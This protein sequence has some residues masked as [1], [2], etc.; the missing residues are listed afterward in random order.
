[1]AT[2]KE[3][4]LMLTSYP[5]PSPDGHG[6]R[7]KEI[8]LNLFALLLSAVLLLRPG[9]L[10]QTAQSTGGAVSIKVGQP[11]FGFNVLPNATRRIFAT[12]SNGTT[13]QVHWSIKSGSA[14]ISSSSGSWIDVTAPV[15][16]TSC[17]YIQTAGQYSVNSATQFTIEATSV[18]DGTKSADVIF[19]VCNPPV[20][21]SVVPFYRTLYANQAADVQSLVVGSVNTNVQWTLS[22]QP[23]GGDGKLIDTTTRDTVFSATVA[24]RYVLTAASIADPRQSSTAIMYVTGNTMPYRVTPNLT[25]P[26]DCTVDPTL[27]GK[28]YE[29]GPSQAF[30]RLQDVPFPRMAPGSTVRVHNEDTTGLHPTEYHEYV[31]ISQPAAADQPFRMCGV[32]DRAG[33]LPVLDAA[34]ATGRSDTSMYAA[35]YGLITLHQPNYWAYWPNFV[36]AAFVQVEGLHIRNATTGSTYTAPNGSTASWGDFSAGIRVNQGEN[37]TFVGNDIGG[38]GNGVFTAWNSGGGWGSADLNVLWEGNHIHNNGVVGSYLSHQMYLQAWGQVVQFN[39]VDSYTA[40]AQGSNIK[41]RGMLDI[42]RYNYLGDGAARQMDL[43][44][45]QDGPAYMSFEG[46]LSGGTHSYKAAYANDSYP[47]DQLAAQQEAYNSNFVYGN[48]YTNSS[49]NVPIH[50]AEDQIGN[51]LARKGSLYWYNNTFYEKLCASCSGQKWTLFDTTAGSGGTIIPQ[52]EYQ[53]VQAFD[54]VIAMDDPARPYFFWNNDSAFI[55]VSGKNLLTTNWGTNDMTGGVGTGWDASEV[56]YQSAQQLSLH[57]TGFNST[58]LQTTSAIP[59][60]KLSLILTSS[61]SGTA[62]LPSA[63]CQ[64]PTRFAYLPSISYAVPRTASLNMGATDTAAQTAAMMNSV[65]GNRRTN[66]RY[67]NCH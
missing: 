39:R 48:I 38:N 60:D 41:S 67:S 14:Q 28:T 27:L 32:P 21:V 45:V 5:E 44:D 18:D 61:A 40:G 51:E 29:V 10:M 17:Q 9:F 35:G 52:V 19:N 66:T 4:C 37:L 22:A 1:M 56:T 46:F 23:A 54:N 63:I 26:V 49:S 36:A 16:G 34:N 12:V 62:T 31:Q 8:V 24:G 33:N 55:G 6:T 65:G 47:A 7:K 42:M 50:Y 53:T 2:R 57:V 43:V 13:N 20:Q 15:T 25:E 3:W 30:K 58:N 64:M 59:F 11:P